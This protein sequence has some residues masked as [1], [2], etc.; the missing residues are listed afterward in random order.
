MVREVQNSEIQS[1]ISGFIEN[2]LT[3]R[4]QLLSFGEPSEG[5]SLPASAGQ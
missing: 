1:V 5:K 3:Y 4:Y 2:D